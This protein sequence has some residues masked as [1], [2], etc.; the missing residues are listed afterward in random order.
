MSQEIEIEFKNILTL[1]E[2]QYL[3][4]SYPFPK[5]PQE[6]INYYFET[7]RLDLHKNR[8]ALRIRKKNDVYQLTLKEPHTDGILETHTTLSKKEALNWLSD[9]IMYKGNVG[10]QLERV[11][12][13]P[14]SLHYIGKLHTTRYEVGI[15]DNLLV[16]DH[17]VYNNHSDYELEIETKNKNSGKVFFERFLADNRIQKKE[18]LNKIERFFRTL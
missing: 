10:D 7:N 15:E 12:I 11:P 13:E 17:S 18:T 6:Q 8:C 2:F 1:A 16:L 4:S 3:L 5:V 14:K 9:N